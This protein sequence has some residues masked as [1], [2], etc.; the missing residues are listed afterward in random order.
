MPSALS[1]ILGS[2]LVLIALSLL[3][4]LARKLLDNPMR[5]VEGGLAWYS[6]RLYARLFHRLRVL[7]PQLIPPRDAGPLILIANHTAGV[8]PIILQAACPGL[9]RF[10]MAQDMRH[11]ALEPIWLWLR[12]IF[13][14]RRA[15]RPDGLRDAIAHLKHSG[16]LAI[17][18]EGAIERPHHTLRPFQPGIGL[19]IKRSGALVQPVIIRGTPDAPSAWASLLRSSSATLEFLPPIDYRESPLTPAQI[20]Q[21]L[22]SRYARSTG[23]S[24]ST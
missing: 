9:L 20:A 2:A 3:G 6:T 5:N 12:V 13:V 21:D 8:D 1:I 23:W 4:L 15:P 19:I 24:T 14:D 16:I 17:F 11:P 18:P 22:H 10:V 7:N